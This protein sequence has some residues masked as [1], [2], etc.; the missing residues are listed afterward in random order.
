M[1]RGGAC[2]GLA[3]HPGESKYLKTLYIQKP[4]SYPPPVRFMVGLALI[5]TQSQSLLKLVTEIN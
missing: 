5:G 3:S 4:G 1:M 2:D